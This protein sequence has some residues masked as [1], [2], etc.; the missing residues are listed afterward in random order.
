MSVIAP[1]YKARLREAQNLFRSQE[2]A[3]AFKLA[4]TLYEDFSQV[5]GV[6]NF[7]N[8]V[9]RSILMLAKTKQQSEDYEMAIHYAQLLL[10]NQTHQEP[11]HKILLAAARAGLSPQEKV[12]MLY[13]VCQYDPVNMSCWREIALCIHTLDPNGANIEIG[14]DVLKVLPGHNEALRGLNLL[15]KKHMAEVSQ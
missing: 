13:Q 2:K 1:A 3:Q 11:V 5:E 10:G 14:F 9:A 7:Y 15:I 8:A 12:A 6:V 4:Q